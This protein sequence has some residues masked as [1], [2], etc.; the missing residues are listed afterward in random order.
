M[1][2]ALLLQLASIAAAGTFHHR[3]LHLLVNTTASV[4][5]SYVRYNES[6]DGL[7]GAKRQ[8]VSLERSDALDLVLSMARKPTRRGEIV[9]G[10]VDAIDDLAFD[11]AARFVHDLVAAQFL[12]PDVLPGPHA[13]EVLPCA[14]AAIEREDCEQGASDRARRGLGDA[15]DAVANAPHGHLA[16]RI[17]DVRVAVRAYAET[18]AKR[19]ACVFCTSEGH[20][21]AAAPESV[22]V[23]AC[24]NP[25]QI[26][27]VVDD[28][29]GTLARSALEPLCRTVES[30]ARIGILRD[31]RTID[32]FVEEFTAR[33][34]DRMVP[35]GEVLDPDAG[36][37]FG[38]AG[39]AQVEPSPLVRILRG[40]EHSGRIGGR[41]PALPPWISNKLYEVMR[42]GAVDMRI[43]RSDIAAHGVPVE[44]G[45][46]ESLAVMFSVAGDLSA[47]GRTDAE[48]VY[49]CAFV[50][51]ALVPSGRF[52]RGLGAGFDAHVRAEAERQ[53]RACAA[54]LTGLTY[55]P[56]ARAGNVGRHPC[57]RSR[58]LVYS[59][60]WSRESIGDIL[61]E[62]LLVSVNGGRITLHH[63]Q[64]GQ[65]IQPCVDTALNLQS[66][67]HPPLCAF[68]AM[69]EGQDRRMEYQWQWREHLGAPF[70]PRVYL[71]D[72][73]VSPRTWNVSREDLW[74]I[75]Q[76]GWRPDGRAL[77][78]SG[79]HK[80]HDWRGRR[81]IPLRVALGSM[82]DFLEL[83]LSC[84]VHAAVFTRAVLRGGSIRETFLGEMDGRDG[85]AEFAHEVIVPMHRAGVAS[86]W[87]GTYTISKP[88]ESGR[89]VRYGIADGVIYAKIYGGPMLLDRFLVRHLAPMLAERRQCG[90]L[91]HWHFVRYSDAR[92]HLRVRLFASEL[93]EVTSL[94]AS[95]ESVCGAREL[96]QGSALVFAQ[97]EPEEWRYGGSA[98]LRKCERLFCIDSEC[99][100]QILAAASE[101]SPSADISGV[102][103]NEDG[104]SGRWLVAAVS[105]HS[106][107]GDLGLDSLA[108]AAF[109]ERAAGGYAQ[110][111]RLHAG[112]MKAINT[113]YR[114]VGR[115]LERSLGEEVSGPLGEL[116]TAM[117]NTRRHQV[118]SLISDVRRLSTNGTIGAPFDD[119]VCSLAHMHCNRLFASRQRQQEAVLFQLLLRASRAT[120][121][122]RASGRHGGA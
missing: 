3:D 82:T 24:D 58:S 98:S 59:A 122:R 107:L 47:L 119:I 8:I 57:L 36:I 110:E 10:L 54:M 85:A 30:F 6:R 9:M 28:E 113:L 73:V 88:S 56:P 49:I 81:E 111:F 104:E 11:E 118:A 93:A 114:R 66:N 83:D 109:V 90:A 101:W 13:G 64:T 43:D 35:L 120:C 61:V 29:V 1:D 87:Q 62:D 15:I 78:V 60:P 121:H 75:G 117:L 95:L 108:I 39:R 19:E 97:Y 34:E 112:H 52:A 20:E 12:V 32:A 4:V 70:L 69:V 105:L 53:Q 17:D 42:S 67:I 41:P 96:G 50:E 79:Y 76:W 86:D 72:V 91:D 55:L 40:A 7:Y 63:A 38:M 33:Y 46:P 65:L 103:G 26:D 37:S 27:L 2:A 45:L 18:L 23:G 51:N 31:R 115:T 92:S 77:T 102:S 80:L 25:V 21:G 74:E 14:I 16:D 5:G 71:D 89:S 94:I 44:D 106:F 116:L 99:V 84:P 100:A 68:F 48:I 22:D